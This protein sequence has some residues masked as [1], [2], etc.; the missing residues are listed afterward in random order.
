MKERSGLGMGP[1]QRFD[2]E[3]LRQDFGEDQRGRC[4]AAADF[5]RAVRPALA[6]GTR[7][8]EV[9]GLWR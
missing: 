9:E 4:A 5:R 3:F 8:M 6:P 7:M 1:D 2:R